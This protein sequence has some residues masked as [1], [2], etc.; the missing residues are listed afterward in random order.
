MLIPQEEPPREWDERMYDVHRWTVM[1]R[2]GHFAPAEEPELA[3]R[4]R[5]AFFAN[6][7]H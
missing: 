4:D 7:G 1:P 2:R 3:A 5:V 6:L